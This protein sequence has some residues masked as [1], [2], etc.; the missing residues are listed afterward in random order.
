MTNKELIINLLDKEMGEEI[1][2]YTKEGKKR[3]KCVC[4]T[5]SEIDEPSYFT[6]ILL[7]D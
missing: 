6:E 2:V 5:E 1:F 3:I 4:S 7:E